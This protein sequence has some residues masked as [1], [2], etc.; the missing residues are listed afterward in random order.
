MVAK[1]KHCNCVQRISMIVPKESRL[2]FLFVDCTSGLGSGLIRLALSHGHCVIATSCNTKN[3]PELVG[4][5]EAHENCNWQHLNVSHST[6]NVFIDN[7]E[8]NGTSID[9]LIYNSN[10]SDHEL[11][12]SKRLTT[13]GVSKH[14]DMSFFAPCQLMFA[15][16]P[17]MRE[18]GHGVI[19]DVSSAIVEV[20]IQR[21]TWT[22]GTS[23]ITSD[24]TV[25]DKSFTHED[26]YPPVGMSY[27]RSRKNGHQTPGKALMGNQLVDHNIHILY[28]IV[29]TSHGGE[30]SCAR[31]IFLEIVRMAKPKEP[32]LCAGTNAKDN[33]LNDR[34]LPF[35]LPLRRSM[36][37]LME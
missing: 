14:L 3:A 4:E 12:I 6:G 26:M 32:A 34:S 8:K 21:V 16:I 10:D 22:R 1:T 30:D 18:R 24:T 13:D 5:V 9:V 27:I 28:N 25:H 7:L 29:Y 11:E 37:T 15:M 36:A 31:D 33:Q 2:T 19:V 23:T 20:P 17:Y 35:K